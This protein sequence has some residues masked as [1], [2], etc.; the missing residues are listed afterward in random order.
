MAT[1]RTLALVL[2]S[3]IVV[4]CTTERP[5]LWISEVSSCEEALLAPAGTPCSFAGMCFRA[6]SSG[7]GCCTHSAYCGASGLVVETSCNSDCAACTDDRDCIKGASICTAQR[8][9]LCPV[10]PSC[11]QCP[12]GWQR[13]ERNGCPTCDC[14]PP[15]ECVP[16]DPNSCVSD[17]LCYTGAHCTAGCA[18]G[19]DCCTN[20]CS[21]QGCQ[22]PAPLGCLKTCTNNP[23][24]QQCAA[25]SC[26]CVGGNWVCTE[27]CIDNENVTASCIAP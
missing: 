4:G 12:N 22:G 10:L 6:W 23:Q 2:A 15:S 11:P 3:G 9:T 21:A 14:A 24:C 20:V 27:R 25:Q 19:D 13:L 17:E 8:C 7:S 18:P 1:L 26:E 5:V 16:T